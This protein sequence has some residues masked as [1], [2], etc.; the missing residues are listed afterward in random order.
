MKLT[1]IRLPGDKVEDTLAL[2]FSGDSHKAT[3]R[4]VLRN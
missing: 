2:T 4:E 3:K 1:Y